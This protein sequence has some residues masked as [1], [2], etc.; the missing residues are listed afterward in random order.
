MA[1]RD[2]PIKR[3]LERVILLTS[4]AVLAL[5]AAVLLTYELFSYK[6]STHRVF[7]TIGQIIADN[8]TAV[9]IY[10]DRKL[11]AEIM[12]G[13][14]AEPEIVLAALYDRNGKL[15]VGY[16]ADRPA[17]AFPLRPGARRT[18]VHRPAMAHAERRKMDAAFPPKMRPSASGPLSASRVRGQC[19]A[20]P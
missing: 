1:F 11:A 3:K 9:L 12:E 13:F 5:M 2:L 15:F 14:R 17:A 4:F 8:S 20:L 7:S 19:R 18:G 10:D 6:R 16:P